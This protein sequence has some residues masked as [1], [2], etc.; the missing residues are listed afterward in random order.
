MRIL[1]PHSDFSM[2]IMNQSWISNPEYFQSFRQCAIERVREGGREGGKEGEGG[3]RKEGME[4]REEGS[5]ILIWELA[6]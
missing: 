1:I 4:G 5:T 3:R 6:A 2:M